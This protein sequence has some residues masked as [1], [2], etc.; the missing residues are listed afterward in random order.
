[1]LSVSQH[2]ANYLRS[3]NPRVRV[4][5]LGGGVEK[6]RHI[7]EQE[8]L[9]ANAAIILV[10]AGVGVVRET[11]RHCFLASM[12]R[13]PHVAFAIHGMDLAGPSENRYREIESACLRLAEQMGLADVVC[14]PLSSVDAESLPSVRGMPWH[15]GPTL[16]AWLDA[17][18]APT[19]DRPHPPS[20]IVNAAQTAGQ[21]EASVVWLSEAPML[22]GRAYLIKTWDKTVEGTISPLKYKINVDTLEHVA[23]EALE[24]NEIGVCELELEE[25]VRFD[26]YGEN[27]HTGSFL[28]IDPIGAQ[29]AGAGMI[30]FALRRAHNVHLQH[31]DVDKSARAVMKRQKPCVLWLT[32]LSGAGKSTV[33]NLVEKALHAEGRHTYLLDGDNVRHGLNKDLGFTAADRVEN[34]RRIAEVARLMVDAGLIVITAFISPFRAERRMARALFDRSE[35]IEV[36]VDAP[37]DIAERRDPKGLYRKARRGELKN[38]TG[39]DSPYEPPEAPEI[40]LDTAVLSREE[41]V[42]RVLEQLRKLESRTE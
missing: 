40:H 10:E 34:I 31:L 23:A 16:K 37:L 20:P 33:A 36:Y 11:R 9:T 13:V 41:A 24:R 27:R 18:Q 42:L 8:I 39:I 38:F 5:I 32:G 29:V 19:K 17:V 25:P 30:R 1:M 12:T 22:R 3:E 14:I 26:A 2:L 21:F 6:P 35:F 7:A 15:P 4:S 28:L